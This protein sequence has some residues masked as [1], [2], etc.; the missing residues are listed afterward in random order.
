M[1]LKRSQG[2]IWVI[3]LW[4]MATGISGIAAADA[5]LPTAIEER[6]SGPILPQ[7]REFRDFELLF[8]ELS[9]FY[10]GREFRPAWIE[11]RRLSGSARR[12]LGVLGSLKC[13]VFGQ[14]TTWLALWRLQNP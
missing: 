11:N 4:L 12:V 13:T 1:K 7:V 5:D 6:L 14:V 9:A 8:G 3:G 10:E 2:Q